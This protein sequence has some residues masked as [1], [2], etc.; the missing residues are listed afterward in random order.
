MSCTFTVSGCSSSFSAPVHPPLQLDTD[1]YE[2]TVALLS[3]V[4]CNS[5]PN[6]E[7]G[8][9]NRMYV[10]LRDSDPST[11][12][13]YVFHHGDTTY[14]IDPPSNDSSKKGITHVF[15]LP[16][17]SY[18]ISHLE[19][20]I[21]EKLQTIL[22]SDRTVQSKSGSRPDDEAIFSLKPDSSI[23]KCRMK[24][25]V[26]DINFTP[27]DSLASMLGF[28]HRVYPAGVMHESEYAVDIVRTLSLRIETNLTTGAYLNGRLGHA[29]YEF[30]PMA[31]PGF[32]IREEPRS[33]T[34]LPLIDGKTL[35]DNISVDIKDQD[36]QPVNFRGEKVVI[37]LELRKVPR[38][39]YVGHHTY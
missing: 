9:N 31:D 23:L 25:D 28:A 3:F 20:A 36:S 34:Y 10:T 8:V 1:H 6:V 33:P 12:I 16:E 30:T 17:G 22:A 32:I 4:S 38:P 35:I 29:I 14:E 13:T 27:R 37:R 39:N 7:K 18:E 19:S 24:S 2:Y 11:S 5:I 21:R 15:D 26:F